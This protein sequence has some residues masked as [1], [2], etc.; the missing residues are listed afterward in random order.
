MKRENWCDSTHGKTACFEKLFV[1][2][3]VQGPWFGI[4]FHCHLSIVWDLNH[5]SLWMFVQKKGKL[6]FF[7]FEDNL[8]KNCWLAYHNINSL[9]YC[10][11]KSRLNKTLLTYCA[12]IKGGLSGAPFTGVLIKLEKGKSTMVFLSWMRSGRVEF[13]V[14]FSSTGLHRTSVN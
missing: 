7:I 13:Q 6:T 14:K 12:V 4:L 10:N 3:M 9:F 11:P 1:T 8:V 5:F 2:Q